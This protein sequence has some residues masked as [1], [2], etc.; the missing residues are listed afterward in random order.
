MH[1]LTKPV[2]VE[3]LATRFREILGAL[4]SRRLR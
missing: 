3:V 4:G 1:M 2:P